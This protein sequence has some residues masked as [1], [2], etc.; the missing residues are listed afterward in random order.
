MLRFA[1]SIILCISILSSVVPNASAQKLSHPHKIVQKNTTA[2]N[3]IDEKPPLRTK[4]LYSLEKVTSSDLPT[5]PIDSVTA[6]ADAKIAFQSAL[7]KQLDRCLVESQDEQWSFA[8]TMVSR[9][10]WCVKTVQWFLAKI[11]VSPTL[12][13]VYQSAKKELQW[14][15]SVGDPSAP[16]PNEVLFTGYYHPLLKAKLIKDAV[17]HYPLYRKPKNVN[18]T[19]AQIVAGALNGQGL[20]IA[21]ASNPVD[22]YLMEVQGSGVVM[23]QNADGTETRVLVNYGGENSYPYTSLGKLMR[24]AGIP[25]EYISLQGIRKYFIDEHPELWEKFSNQNESYVF[26]TEAADGPYGSAGVILTPGHSIAVDLK[27]FPLGAIALVQ[28]EKPTNTTGEDVDAWQPFAQFMIS[29]DTGGA[30]KGPG[31]IDI[32]WGSG[33]YAEMVAGHSQQIGRLYFCLVP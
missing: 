26:F 31:H 15:R 9:K 22:P 13:D 12:E 14:Y 6:G 3:I 8:G 23:L 32:Y 33:P 28:S 1:P 29:Q 19:R 18:Y 7:Q 2:Q 25:D 17:Y 30:I 4:A 21:Y 20:E 16:S 11:A 27:Q 24:A 5:L 10:Q